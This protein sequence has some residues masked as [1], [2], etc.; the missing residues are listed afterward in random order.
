M[1]DRYRQDQ[2]EAITS[3]FSTYN[4]SAML[5]FDVDFGHTDP[6][7]V[8][9]YGGIVTIDGPSRSITADYRAGPLGDRLA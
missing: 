9:P 5:V 7:L 2:R 8:L 3:V 6:Q 1:R 4:P